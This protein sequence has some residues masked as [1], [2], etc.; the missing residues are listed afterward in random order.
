MSNETKAKIKKITILLFAF[1][2]TF[3]IRH[4]NYQ[5][6]LMNEF[7]EIVVKLSILGVA[8]YVVIF[9]DHIFCDYED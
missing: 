6:A 3:F 4:I 5:Y 1:L 8:S 2:L 9:K 7:V